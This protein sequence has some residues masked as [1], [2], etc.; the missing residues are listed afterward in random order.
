M[1]NFG[2][3]F[4]VDFVVDGVF[5]RHRFMG[6]VVSQSLWLSSSLKG[7]QDDR[8]RSLLCLHLWH[9]EIRCFLLWSVASMKTGDQILI[10]LISRDYDSCVFFHVELS[11]VFAC[12]PFSTSG[13]IS[14]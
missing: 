7:A 8:V 13:S 11:V 1:Y 4:W 5:F 12:V 10:G 6:D 14:L 2:V 3:Y 9:Y